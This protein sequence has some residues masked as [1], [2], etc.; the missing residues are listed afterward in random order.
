MLRPKKVQTQNGTGR[1]YFKYNLCYREIKKNT[2]TADVIGDR[3][4][5]KIR[6]SLYGT[7]FAKGGLIKF[8]VYVSG[9]FAT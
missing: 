5:F 6:L 1:I 9:E 7:A 8:A 4:N 2:H 3:S